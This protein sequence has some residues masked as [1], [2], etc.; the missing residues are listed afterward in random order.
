MIAVEEALAFVLENSFPLKESEILPINQCINRN[1]AKAVKAP[2]DLPSFRLSSVDGYA[3]CL[4]QSNTYSIVDEV[5]AGDA[6][7]PSLKIGECVRIFTGAVVP[8]NADAVI[9][10]EKT[11]RNQDTVTIEAPVNKG[12][13]IRLRGS[14]VKKGDFPLKKGQ[15]LQASGLAFLKSLGIDQVEVVRLPKVTIVITGNELITSSE[16]L[17]RGKIYESNSI[18]LQ[19]A[20]L[21]QGI[22]TQLI[23]FT[24]DS[25]KETINNLKKAF[26]NSDIVLVS[27]GIS[28]G[29]YD[30]VKQALKELEVKE[31][32]YKV[33]QR[34][35][36]PLFFGKKDQGFVFALP[37]NPASTLS[38]F[39]VYVLPLLTRLK[40][41]KSNGLIRVSIPIAHDFSSDEPRALFL[42]A[43]IQNKTVSILDGQHSSML[44]SFAKANA[45]VYI[46]EQGVFLKKG[47]L[48]ETLLLPNTILT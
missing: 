22:E 23:S 41:G 33:R 31:I 7:N 3:L 18:L 29:D 37:G 45:L 43:T 48:V 39:Y 35:G 44:V 21:N 8:D 30:F 10:Q 1:L 4:H 6:A 5:K 25:L 15:V 46:P 28:V 13:N 26:F 36:K 11:I 17:T 42:K 12:Q 40:G 27:G 34:P 24:E 20:L 2:I 38:C 9:M 14:Q 47:S 16:K 32:F 19:A